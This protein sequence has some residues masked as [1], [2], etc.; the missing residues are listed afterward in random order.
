[1]VQLAD[2]NDSWLLRIR[3]ERQKAIV[4]DGRELDPPHGHLGWDG[5]RS[6]A[7]RRDV[8]QRGAAPVRDRILLTAA[9]ITG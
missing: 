6:L 3:C 7:E 5:W 1:L 2:S 9:D 8:H 4:S